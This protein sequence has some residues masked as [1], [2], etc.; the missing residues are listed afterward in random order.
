MKK[1]KIE[2]IEQLFD[3]YCKKVLKNK[4]YYIFRVERHQKELFTSLDK[5]LENHFLPD[6]LLY[7]PDFSNE[8]HIFPLL[9]VQL[10]VSLSNDALADA[11]NLLKEENREIILLHY[12]LSMTDEE[13][14]ARF[15]KNRINIQKRRSRSIEKLRKILAREPK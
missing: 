11:L 14:G 10:S 5:L 2:E 13:I 12:F 3:S 7:Q 9:T 15:Q 1:L 6:E 4:A 8:Q